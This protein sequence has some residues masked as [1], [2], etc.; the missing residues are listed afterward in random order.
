MED[1]LRLYED[2]TQI[3]KQR[4]LSE[5]QAAE[6]KE[7]PFSPYRQ[8]A[9]MLN[10]QGPF[11]DNQYN[12]S[13]AA[14][15]LVS[16]A[17]R[18]YEVLPREVDDDFADH[19]T[20]DYDDRYTSRYGDT[21]SFAGT[22]AYAP[23]KNMF[24]NLDTNANLKEKDLDKEPLDGEISEEYRISPARKRWMLLV[25][26]LTCFV[27]HWALRKLP[28]FRRDDIRQ[29]WK[30]KLTI[31]LIIWFI[32]GCAVFVIAILGNLICPTEHVYSTGELAAHNYDDDPSNAYVSIRG[33]VGII[34]RPLSSLRQ[35]DLVWLRT[36]L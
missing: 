17:A 6:V 5:L 9:L 2:D 27:P 25:T 30:E 15:P 32:C 1:R 33:E 29:A 36:G 12:T 13:H 31:N 24:D 11:A 35:T 21:M 26:M 16:Q 28:R 7:D 23:S 10:Y 3:G 4:N 8:S 19:K 20:L 18:E 34:R 14:L 22:E